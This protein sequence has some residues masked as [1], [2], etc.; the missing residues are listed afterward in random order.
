MAKGAGNDL[1]RSS[2][3]RQMSAKLQVVGQKGIATASDMK[4]KVEEVGLRAQESS[5]MKL[6]DTLESA[7]DVAHHG[8]EKVQ[9]ITQKLKDASLKFFGK[10]SKAWGNFVS[11]TNIHNV[12][13]DLT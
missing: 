12:I 1:L 4:H 11:N 8:L 10:F 9:E 13:T 3:V 5:K 7:S 6:H 2:Q